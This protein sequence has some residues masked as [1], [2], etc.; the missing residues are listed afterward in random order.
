MYPTTHC[1]HTGTTSP[2]KPTNEPVRWVQT[3]MGRV[4]TYTTESPSSN[5]QT[6]G[7]M[8]DHWVK[9]DIEIWGSVFE[10]DESYVRRLKHFTPVDQNQREFSDKYGIGPLTGLTSPFSTLLKHVMPSGNLKNYLQASVFPCLCHPIQENSNRNLTGLGYYNDHTK[11][12][13]ICIGTDSESKLGVTEKHII[14]IWIIFDWRSSIFVFGKPSYFC[15]PGT[16][17]HSFL[18]SKTFGL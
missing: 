4:R 7:E 6:R 1:E 12:H 11:G 18:S 9:S 13:T 3:C 15:F 17:V 16:R 5:N 14:N 8:N 10:M 2:I